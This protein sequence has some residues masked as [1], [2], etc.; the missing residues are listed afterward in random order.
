MV[1][2]LCHRGPD[3]E[4]IHVGDGIALGHRRL[5]VIDL[6][7]TGAQPMVDPSTG[8]GV[9]YN[10]ESYNF[11]ELRA[12]LMAADVTFTGQSDTEV[13]LRAYTHWGMD[14]LRRLEGIFAFALWDP[15]TRR[16][17]LMRDRLGVKPL[18]YGWSGESLVF[19][20][21]I[22]A[23]LAAGGMDTTVD[24][25]AFRE[26]LW[27]GN[28]FEDRT[29]YRSIRA[30]MPGHW[31]IVENG[32]QRVEPYW[33]LEDW[34]T[35][36]EPADERGA[37]E[38]VRQAVDAAVARQLVA[39]VPV[40]IF[41]SGGVDSSSIAASAVHASGQRLSSYS[42]G[43]DFTDH[44]D[45]LPA[46]RRFADR[47]GLDHHELHVSGLRLG[48]VLEELAGAHDEPFGDAAN[49]PLFLLAEQLKGSVK[50]VLQGDG[51]DEMFAGYRRY[52][53]LRYQHLWNTWPRSLTSTLRLGGRTAERVARGA[54]ALRSS[55]P[56]TRM[57]LLLTL[58]TMHDP[59]ES[60]FTQDA[61]DHLTRDCDAFLAYRNSAARFASYE[62]VQQ[63]LLTDI[64]LQLPSQYLTK[65][66]RATMAQGMEARVP[67]LDEQVARLAIGM[68]SRFKV[69]GRQKKVV[70]RTA[71]RGRVPD[72]VLDGPKRGFGV[73]FSQWLRHQLYEQAREA[74]LAEQVVD[75]FGLDRQSVAT[76]FHQHRSG[77]RDRGVL[78]WKLFQLAL[79]QQVDD[80]RRRGAPASPER[81]LLTGPPVGD[82]DAVT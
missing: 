15:R 44:A 55:D 37:A 41:L 6:T 77:E 13:M 50:V 7:E 19:G 61:R 16:L 65:V 43:F 66:D 80:A 12:E 3:G 72:D 2:T 33:R 5:C 40:G 26:F 45:E 14:G 20:S 24:P 48:D 62:P 73:P 32:R 35:G 60:V 25:Q 70:L 82:R 75:R 51:G 67:L 56:A 57:A 59:P 34:L 18:F 30:L 9:A 28:S 11:R 64:S 21:E 36:P 76:Y 23:V 8:V 69:H 58:E 46:A 74:V 81:R 38:A 4:G 52:A 63:M 22:K 39:D 71:M 10:G 68:P 42:V 27:F 53:L 49:I 78:L 17:L 47:L 79:W 31:L 1:A 54:A 29:I